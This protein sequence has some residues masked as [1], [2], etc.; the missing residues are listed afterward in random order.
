MTRAR[1]LVPV[2]EI[3]PLADFLKERDVRWDNLQ[4]TGDSVTFS[5]LPVNQSSTMVAE[6]QTRARNAYDDV[7]GTAPSQN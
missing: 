6:P 5:R 7:F 3:T 2:S 4:V 1:R